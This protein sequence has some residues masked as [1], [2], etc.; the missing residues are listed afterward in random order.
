MRAGDLVADRFEI[1][2]HA[3][4]GGMAQIFRA[5][6]R[7]TGEPVAL[8]ILQRTGPQESHRFRREAHALAAL[9]HPGIVAYVAH[10][11]TEGGELYLAMQWLAGETLAERLI[12][13]P[14][15]VPESLSLGVRVAST[16]GALHRLGIVHRDLKPSNLLL[17]GGSVDEVTLLDFGVARVAEAGQEL[18]MPG[19]MLGTPGYMA[20]EQ[21]RGEPA[22]DARADVFALGCVLYRCLTGRPPFVGNDGLSVLVKVLLEDPPRLR[23]L[24]GE[25]P[26]ALD[27]LV[28][29][30]LAKA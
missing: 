7:L 28:T 2:G 3:T 16:L 15:T 14:L 13:E 5:R 29:R 10:G 9:R 21:A 18:T 1:E 11:T 8:K 4:S 6:D 23:E 25:V 30:M 17:V 19:V 26:A 24:R 22:I 12:R 27:D 20:P